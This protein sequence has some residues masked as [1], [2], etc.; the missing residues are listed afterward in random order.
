MISQKHGKIK[1]NIEKPGKVEDKLPDVVVSSKK[2]KS[3]VDAF[4]NKH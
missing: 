2:E 3:V 1:L 4:M